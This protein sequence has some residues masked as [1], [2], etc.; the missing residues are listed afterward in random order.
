ML[1]LLL[2]ACAPALNWREVRPEGAG[3]VVLFPC[4]PA[5]HARSVALA[6]ASSRMTIHACRADD[7]VYAIGFAELGDPWRVTAAL[8]QLRAAALHNIA[9][10]QPTE[11]T[12]AAVVGM[13]PNDE[14][15]R[16]RLT[17]RRPD[18]VTVHEQLTVF[19]RGTR[20]YQASVIGAR[21]DTSA[22]EWFFAN[23][24]LSV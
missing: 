6:G 20:V 15:L 14:S 5:S 3:L 17:G 19:A 18:G 2:G 9:S 13:T 7:V 12:P 10:A 16:L 4:K 21:L 11:S 1:S 8:A 24:K 23:L 22:A